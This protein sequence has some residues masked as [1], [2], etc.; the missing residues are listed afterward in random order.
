MQLVANPIDFISSNFK[1]APEALF[2]KAPEALF[3]KAPEALFKKAPEALDECDK[4][5]SPIEMLYQ[6][7]LELKKLFLQTQSK[8]DLHLN[9]D[10]LNTIQTIKPQNINLRK[11]LAQR[12]QFLEKIIYFVGRINDFKK[13]TKEIP[14]LLFKKA[15]KKLSVDTLKKVSDNSLLETL[16]NATKELS[17]LTLKNATEK[18]SLKIFTIATEELPLKLLKIAQEDAPREIVEE[19]YEDLLPEALKKN[20]DELPLQILQEAIIEYNKKYL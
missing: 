8:I 1:K 3:K 9:G 16:K 4:Y 11:D 7:L 5:D 2:K 15:I 18:L 17:Q 19:A 10:P 13:A 6:K 20:P 14:L 12:L